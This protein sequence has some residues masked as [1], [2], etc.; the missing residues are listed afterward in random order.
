ML[1][2]RFSRRIVNWLLGGYLEEL[3]SQNK[4]LIRLEKETLRFLQMMHDN[5]QKRL[6]NSFIRDVE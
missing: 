4:E 2:R 3:S 1:L 6:L 5:E